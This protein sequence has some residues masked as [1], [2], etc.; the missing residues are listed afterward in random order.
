M[1]KLFKKYPWAR[2]VDQQLSVA[3]EM[4]FLFGVESLDATDEM[5]E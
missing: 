4:A 2:E 1:E 5:H 3:L